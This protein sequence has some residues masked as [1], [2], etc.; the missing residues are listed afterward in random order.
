MDHDALFPLAPINTAEEK[1]QSLFSSASD[2]LALLTKHF[3]QQSFSSQSLNGGSA[4]VS[5]TADR[6]RLQATVE[7]L[8]AELG[9]L[10]FLETVSSKLMEA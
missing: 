10:S 1:L 2:A 5:D 9:V 8:Q 4:N 3:E 6:Q 7:R